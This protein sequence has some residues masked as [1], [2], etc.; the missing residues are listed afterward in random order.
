MFQTTNM[1]P[2]PGRCYLQPSLRVNKVDFHHCFW[3]EVTPQDLML[4]SATFF[5]FRN[6]WPHLG[7]KKVLDFG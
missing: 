4:H 1:Y 5:N 6:G 3:V 7:G 2:F